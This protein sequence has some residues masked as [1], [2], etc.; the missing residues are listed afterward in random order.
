M[1]VRPNDFLC[2]AGGDFVGPGTPRK[3]DWTRLKG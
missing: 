2:Y 3:L 1:K